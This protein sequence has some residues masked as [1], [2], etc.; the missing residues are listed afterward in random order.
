MTPTTEIFYVLLAEFDPDPDPIPNEIWV[1][2]SLGEAEAHLRTFSEAMLSGYT[3]DIDNMPPDTELVA[4]F[5]AAGT[6]IHLYECPLDRSSGL[7]LV[8]F[9]RV[10]E[11]LS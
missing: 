9:E 1:C 2:S 6:H 11:F 4:A 7:E 3:H 8:P 10:P 5:R